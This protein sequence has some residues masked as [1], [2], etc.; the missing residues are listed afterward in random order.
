MWRRFVL[1]YLIVEFMRI[2][3]SISFIV[4]ET[5]ATNCWTVVL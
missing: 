2:E 3:Y 5:Y 1:L 4:L